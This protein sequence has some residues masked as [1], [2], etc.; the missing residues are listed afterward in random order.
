MNG[1]DAVLAA[2]LL[3]AL[4]GRAGRWPDG[5]E[6]ADDWEEVGLLLD[7][8]AVAAGLDTEDLF[9]AYRAGHASGWEDRDERSGAS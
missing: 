5:F 2:S 6:A 9:A 1:H 4:H 3:G 7:Q 8:L